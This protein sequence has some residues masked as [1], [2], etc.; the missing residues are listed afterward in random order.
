[1][2]DLALQSE[3]GVRA[4]KN[5]LSEEQIRWLLNSMLDFYEHGGNPVTTAEHANVYLK[6]QGVPENI[7]FTGVDANSFIA[8]FYGQDNHPLKA[9]AIEGANKARSVL[10]VGEELLE[11]LRMDD[12][13]QDNELVT[14]FDAA[15]SRLRKRD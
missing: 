14:E 6:A 3:A 1:M 10:D 9:Y 12:R 4:L 13:W 5:Y 2:K 11:E 8:A 7:R 15:L